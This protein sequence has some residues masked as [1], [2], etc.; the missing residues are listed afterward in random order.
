MVIIYIVTAKQ[1]K[2]AGDREERVKRLVAALLLAMLFSTG[3]VAQPGDVRATSGPSAEEEKALELVAEIVTG[4]GVAQRKK[5]LRKLA[6]YR[7]KSVAFALVDMLENSHQAPELAAEVEWALVSMSNLAVDPLVVALAEG[8]VPGS[9]AL[10]VLKRLARQEPSLVS[11]L[12]LHS[13]PV[14]ARTSALALAL[15]GHPGRMRIVS[16]AFDGAQ[17]A[18]QIAILQGTCNIDGKGCRTLLPL[19]FS[20]PDSDVQIAALGLARQLGDTRMARYCV[21]LLHRDSGTL[22]RAALET[23]IVLGARGSEADLQ[24]LFDPAPD[25]IKEQILRVLAQTATGEA[26]AFLKKVSGRYSR[27]SRVGSL[28]HSLHRQSAGRMVFMGDTKETLPV[29]ASLVARGTTG[30]RLILYNES[31]FRVLVAGQL[32]IRCPGRRAARRKV[33]TADFDSEG[34][35]PVSAA[36]PRGLKPTVIWIR[37]DGHKVEASPTQF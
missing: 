6:I 29:E 26:F 17:P 14:I 33:S 13:E 30:T 5:L 31:G 22:V 2:R 1:V 27:R 36:C 9:A 16:D 7:Y 3:A 18:A 25:D 15:C 11:H 23:L 35:L 4:D 32:E 24:I 12:L 34:F 28:A 37:G 10:V 19:A 21:P 8:R 20:S